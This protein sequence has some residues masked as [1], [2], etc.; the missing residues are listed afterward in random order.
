MSSRVSLSASVM[1]LF[2][3]IAF[4]PLVF[5][6]ESKPENKAWIRQASNFGR[7]KQARSRCWNDNFNNIW[8]P[9]VSN[10]ADTRNPPLVITRLKEI[11]E[12]PRAKENLTSVE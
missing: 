7:P 9:E 6:C 8:V 4:F 12:S 5:D 1:F 3:S 11:Q 10:T 2:S